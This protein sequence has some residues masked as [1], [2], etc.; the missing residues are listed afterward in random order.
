MAVE[1]PQIDFDSLLKDEPKLD[2]GL[3]TRPQI[4]FNA[5]LVEPELA[6]SRAV[7]SSYVDPNSEAEKVV[8]ARKLQETFNEDWSPMA[9]D[10]AEA[11]RRLGIAENERILSENPILS[12]KFTDST[13]ANITHKDLNNLGSLERTVT[14]TMGDIGVTT[15]KGLIGV[16]QFLVGLANIPTFGYAGKGLE[17]IGIDLAEA[18]DILDTMY[19]PAQQA[20]NRRVQ[21]AEGFIDTLTAAIE[22][23]STI[24]TTVGESLPS[25]F[26]G[27]A[28]G[29]ALL[30]AGSR[31]LGAGMA[32]PTLPGY[33]A[34]VLGERGAGIV[35]GAAGEGLVAAGTMAEQIRAESEEGL[36]TGKQALASLGAGFGT[37]VIGAVGGKAAQ[38]LKLTDIDTLIAEGGEKAAQASVAKTGFMRNVIGSG[39]A[40]GVFEELPQSAQEQ[41]WQN[42]AQDRPVLEGVGSAAAMGFL[43]GAATGSGA[44]TVKST[45]D[46]LQQARQAETMAQ[47]IEQITQL[48]RASQVLAAD[49]QTFRDFMQDVGEA[50]DIR[51]LFVDARVLAQ[52]ISESGVPVQ[53]L[54]AVMPGITQ[55]ITT[56][57]ALNESVAIPLADFAT[58]IA[59]TPLADALVP[60]LRTEGGMSVTEA[61][62]VIDNAAEEFRGAIE[63]LQTTAQQDATF[64]KSFRAV[65]DNLEAQVLAASPIYS[66]QDARAAATLEAARYAALARQLNITP[67]EALQRFPAIIAREGQAPGGQVLAMLDQGGVEVTGQVDDMTGLPLNADGTVTLYHHTSAA[68][69]ESIRRSGALRSAGEPSVYLTTRETPDTGYGD[70][71]VKVRIDPAKLQLDDEFPDGRR[72][73]SVDV[74]RPGGALRGAA[75]SQGPAFDGTETP[76][77]KAWF[78]NSKVVDGQGNPLRVFRGEHGATKTGALQTNLPSLTFTD[79][80]EVAS[81]YAEDP[82]D[83]NMTAEAPR[84][85][86]AYLSIQNPIFNDRNDPFAEFGDIADKL[87]QET[88]IRFALKHEGHIQNTGN[89]SEN[90]A[91]Q[92]RSVEQLLQERPEAIRELYMTAFVLLDDPEFVQA[93]KDAG[94]D[95]GIHLG[96]GAS[97][98]AIEFRVFDESQVRSAMRPDVLFQAVSTRLPTAKKALENPLEDMLIIGLDAAKLD[99]DAFENNM[100]V[101]RGYPNM[102]PAGRSSADTIAER[103][104]QH[105]VDNLLWLHDQIDPEIRERSRMWYDGARAI[106]D[107][108]SDK[109]GLTDAQ[110]SAALAVLSPQKD[111]FMNVSLAE[112]VLDIMT[113]QQNFMWS[114]EMADKVNEILI[115]SEEEQQ[116]LAAEE[117]AEYE[118]VDPSRY[119]EAIK[120]IQGKTLREVIEAGNDK[121]TAI[122]I[123]VYDQAY[124]TR[125]YRIVSPEGDF[126]DWK[127]NAPTKDQARKGEPGSMG[128][129]AWGS[130]G[131]I[132]KAVSVIRDG[133]IENISNKLGGQHKVRNF[134]NNIFN[135]MSEHGDVTIDTHA[136]AAALLRPLAGGSDEVKHNFGS[137]GVSNSSVFGSKGTYGIYAEAYRRAARERGILPREMQSITWEAVR[138]LFL[139]EQKKSLQSTVNA[140]WRRYRK[141]E[142]TID[143]AR[144]ETL[145]LA[146]GIENPDWVGRTRGNGDAWAS[147]YTEELAGA[148][149][150]GRGGVDGRGVGRNAGRDQGAGGT[151]GQAQ[152]LRQN[153]QPTFYS[154][155]ERSIAQAK[156]TSAPAS[157]WLAIIEKLPGVKKD[158]IEWSGIREYLQ[159]RGKDKVTR[160]ELVNYMRQNGVE[161]EETMLS[162][163]TPDIYTEDI[164]DQLES[165]ETPHG[166][167]AS[168]VYNLSYIMP[169]TSR[170]TNFTAYE[171]ADGLVLFDEGGSYVDEFGSLDEIKEAIDEDVSEQLAN[172]YVS[173]QYST[174]VL[175]G[176]ENYR[177]LLLRLP[178]D[179]KQESYDSP[180]WSKVNVFAH[181]RFNERTDADGNRVLFIEEIQSDWAQEGRKKGF[182]SLDAKKQLIALNEEFENIDR[183]I[184][185][186]SARMQAV[187]GGS[188]E[189]QRLSEERQR[190]QDQQAANIDRGNALYDAQRASIPDAPFVKDTKAWVALAVKRMV[191]YAAENGFDKI[192]FVNGK[193]SAD[194]YD[195][196]KK[197]ATLKVIKNMDGSFAL[198]IK[199]EASDRTFEMFKSRVV[200]DELSDVIGKELANRI[201]QDAASDK[202][203]ERDYSGLDLQVGGEGMINFYDKIVPQVVNDVLKKLGGGKLGITTINTAD[204]YEQLQRAREESGMTDNE[205]ANLR[206]SDIEKLIKPVLTEQ[207]AFDITPEMRDTVM[208]GQ[209]LFQNQQ[210]PL[211]TFNPEEMLIT[212]G[213]SAN[214]STFLHES[215]HY[216][217]EV[218]A[219]IAGDPATPQQIR[220]DWATAMAWGGFTQA[221]WDQWQAEYQATKKIPAGM[222]DFHE[223][224]AESFE[225]YLFEGKAP[226]AE[227]QPL[228]RRF[229]SWLLNVY[230]SLWRFLQNRNLQ[231]NAE[232]RAVFDRMLATDEQIRQ[233][234]EAAGLLPD[235]NA[236]NEAIEQLQARSLRDL[237]WTINARGRELKKLE[238]EA[239]TLRKGVEAEVRAEVERQPI[240]RAMTWLKKGEM[241]D[242]ATGDLIKADKGFRLDTAALKEMYPESMLARPD[243]AKL[244]GMTGK[245]GLHPDLVAEMFGFETG[246]AL[247]RAII[248]AEP[249]QSVVDGITDQR[250]LERHGDLATPEAREEAANE[251]VHNEARARALATELKAQSDM[252]RE[253]Q[254]TGRTDVR[255]RPITV[256]ALVQA[257]KDFGATIAA[258]RPVRELKNAA[259][260]HRAA[261]ARAGK[262]WDEATRKGQTE[263]AVQ[264]KRD[265]MLNNAAAKALQEAQAE[266][267]EIIAFFRRVVKDSNEKIVKKGRD[268]DVVNAMRAILAAYGVAP[269]LGKSALEYMEAV[270]RNDPAMYNALAPGVQTALVNAMPLQELTMEELRGLN[271]ELRAMWDLAKR[272]RKMEIDGN[273]LD[274]EDLE[275]EL[276][277][278]M[279]QIGIPSSIPGEKGAIT[280]R[281]ER[282]IKLQFAKAILSRVEQWAERLDGKF[283]GPFLR[284]VFQPIKLAADRYRAARV[285]YRKRFTEL[286]QAVAPQLPP[287]PIAAPELGYTFGNARDSGAAELLHAILHT[288]NDSNKRKL[289]L[290]RG[291]ASENADGSLNTGPLPDG[292]QGWDAFVARMYAEGKLNQAHYDFAQGVWDLLEQMKPLAQQAHRDVFGR[293]F[294]EVTANEVVTPFGTYRGGYVPAQTDTRLVKD[295]RLRELA[296][297]ENEGMAY[298]FPAAPSGFTKSRVEYNKPL[299]LDLRVLAQHMDKVLL[300]SYMQPAVNDVRR[301]LTRKGVS[302]ALDRI[303]P[304]AYEGMLIPWL[305]RS[306]RQ[307][308]ETPVM[309][310]RK[311]SRFLSAMRSRAGMA[312]MFA[313]LSNTVQ[314]ITGFSL[315]AVKVRP[316][317]MLDAAAAFIRDPKGVKRTVADA[318]PYMKDR[319][320]N[321]VGALNDAV[322]RILVNPTWLERSQEWTQQHAYFLQAAVDNTMSPIIWTAAYNQAIGE[323][324][325]EAEAIRFADGVVR[326]TQGSTLPEDISRFESG[327]AY[328]RLFTQ[329]VSYFNMM[330]NTNATAVKQITDEMGLKRGAGRLLYVALA[331]LLAPIWV[332]EAIAQAFRG[333]PE[334]EDDDGYLDDWLAAVFGLGTVRGLLAQI[335]IV[336]QA[337]QIAVNR[338]NDNPADDK[339]S[340]SPA[341]S[342]VESAVGA[343][344]SVY[345]AIVED[346]NAQ[347]ALRDVAAAATL[348]TGL[349]IYAGVRPLGYAAG[350][351]QEKIQP[352]GPIDLT[353]G[354]ITGTASA[355]SRT[356]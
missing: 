99:R 169:T 153:V 343:P 7:T 340:L 67:E 64:R 198:R 323:Q 320:L 306:A 69:A 145:R 206:T 172:S 79:D 16:P 210:A 254:D 322:E 315:A 163:V 240:Y 301:L 253:R 285:D 282:S 62:A 91:D 134:Y 81:L 197:I 317:L 225:A 108:W 327:P 194:R 288:G 181:I 102:R 30:G 101:V 319:M 339:F 347:K 353:R 337:A 75:F 297:G 120:R 130:F 195:L 127:R 82:N 42:W 302:T 305:N 196:S 180:H 162:N 336:G 334:D 27:G 97:L 268:P 87:G 39:I 263:A 294:N 300:F 141:G 46:R 89:W 40:E 244:K 291:W 208:A 154:Q 125:N 235:F 161:I 245:E 281:E 78:G 92:Y 34:R 348:V 95:G 123:R 207:L 248:N 205:W 326:Q 224:W 165:I 15:V 200:E 6:S 18:Q 90:F 36:L 231:M 272:S 112:R 255:G 283:G 133:S 232:I 171:T 201:V 93:A 212:L 299:L 223:R 80:P 175:P 74:G 140:V 177:E 98:D 267:R 251:A 4:D 193:Q 204:R 215:G 86:P 256:N 316:G 48:A 265:Q 152:V 5:L 293:Y 276:M 38:K 260:Q 269:R 304:G 279:Q 113:G 287:G 149:L 341:V 262:R 321:E 77:F 190:L 19:S 121:D 110:V 168:R 25:M 184:K 277:D 56:A 237:R 335:P 280:D 147:S 213:E 187:E 9:V 32:G 351:A 96:T 344:V 72:D 345:N 21:Q 303:D 250:M 124:N 167:M 346:G 247:V 314:Q 241:V 55:Q 313:N 243:T 105:V 61:R 50:S 73:F 158:E 309:G 159:L 76:D 160:D 274:L 307:I 122:W 68:N 230:Q 188:P 13:F 192:A 131:E 350:V 35:A 170:L 43:A 328:G 139:A 284:L 156:Q 2:T 289:L 103:F 132:S 31:V 325:T 226:S 266:V 252:L 146:N 150:P 28:I 47:R 216:F 355:E 126:Q 318:S 214:L 356:P 324:M 234:E 203:F 209:P 199:R 164:T 54:E 20:A 219:D 65:R 238:K 3:E 189:W 342:L 24:L 137:G 217:L 128:K 155:L 151:E 85:I 49:P 296:E 312:L 227:L 129:V 308:V 295:A 236:T 41:M 310:D 229:R 53:Q 88:A 144:A 118:P 70:T 52:R 178:Y 330:A 59:P 58:H 29:R 311:I 176:G 331:G 182:K 114:P 22:N 211:G 333:G 8:L 100:Q 116:A 259:W 66:K 84:V 290:G 278:R 17:A 264:A 11:R 233:A 202:N 220:D 37:G 183:E 45:A 138:G 10:P 221:Q 14:G 271:D 239:K 104:I 71:V 332:A 143:E 185:S 222:R 26:G 1:Y 23:P 258:R 166:D 117:G 261:E 135:P 349:P 33:L 352:T 354:L 246:D 44:A 218:L 83:W 115:K 298:A 173:P 106:V 228:F 109:Y 148:E 292:R 329:F 286:L 142:V 270:K 242:E 119:Y 179:P 174:Y 157:D 136:V 273:L 12:R 338:I 60:D 94:Y 57:A 107:R 51:E 63:T 257:A 191:R 111:W 249:I 275:Q 186:I